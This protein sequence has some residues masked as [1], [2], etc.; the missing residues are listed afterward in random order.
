MGKISER[1]GGTGFQ[2]Q[3]AEVMAVTGLRY[4]TGNI[5]NSIVAAVYAER[6]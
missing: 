2:L 1:V 3:N 6:W 4:S 5:V